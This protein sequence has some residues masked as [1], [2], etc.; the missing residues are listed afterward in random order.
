MWATSHFSRHPADFKPS[1]S[2]PMQT[3]ELF[4]SLAY[5]YSGGWLVRSVC[6]MATPARDRA[7]VERIK[8]GWRHQPLLEAECHWQRHSQA[9]DEIQPEG[10]AIG[11]SPKRP[12][13]HTG[14]FQ[15]RWKLLFLH[16]ACSA[17]SL[18]PAVGVGEPGVTARDR[19]RAGGQENVGVPADH[20]RTATLLTV[21]RHGCVVSREP[22]CPTSQWRSAAEELSRDP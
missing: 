7:G 11:R 21:L 19:D 22:S 13:G 20:I 9:M 5:P 16:L 4:V 2:L 6:C 18:A 10:N 1:D 15:S 12:C 17:P 8:I 3:S 14:S